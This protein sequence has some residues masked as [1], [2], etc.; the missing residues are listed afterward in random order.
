MYERLHGEV[1][2]AYPDLALV[3]TSLREAHTASVNDWSAVGSTR[4]AFF[5]GPKMSRLDIF[6]RVGGRDSFA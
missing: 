3:A 2:D 4:E 1:L 5:V 6:D